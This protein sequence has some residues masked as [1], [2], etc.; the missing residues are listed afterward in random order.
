MASFG[1]QAWDTSLVALLASEMNNEISDTLR[2]GHDLQ[3]SQDRGLFSDQDHGW[4]L[5][6]CTAEAQ[7]P[8]GFMVY[9][10]SL[11]LAAAGKSYSTSATVQKA[12]N[13]LLRTQRSD[14]GL[15]KATV[16]VLTRYTELGNR[17]IKSVQTAWALIHSGQMED[18]DFPQQVITLQ[19][20]KRKPKEKKI[21]RPLKEQVVESIG[22]K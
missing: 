21:L 7:K 18:G 10:I 3:K 9:V 1:S 13:F 4:Q 2:K 22:T 5:S 11:G 6:D 14:G 20:K 17:S 19:I 15:E 16:L 8:E 12:L